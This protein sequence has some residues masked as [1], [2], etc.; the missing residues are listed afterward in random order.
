MNLKMH[1][2]NKLNFTKK[3]INYLK[4]I[5]KKT[6]ATLTLNLDNN[7]IEMKHFSGLDMYKFG[8]NVA[9]CKVNI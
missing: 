6:K 8:Y 1:R 2:K 3:L 4:K 5:I 7:S 9:K